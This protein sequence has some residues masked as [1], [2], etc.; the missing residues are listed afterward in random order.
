MSSAI[1]YFDSPQPFSLESGD[2]LPTLRI[3]YQTFGKLNAQQD[4]VIWVCHALTGNTEIDDWWSGL[5]GANNV[6]DPDQY[7]IV[8]ANMLGSCYGSTDALHI[9]PAT[10]TSW[11][12]NFPPI[13]NRDM[14][15]AFDMLRQHLGIRSIYLIT[16]GSMGGQHALEW[17]ISSPTLFRY[18]VPMATNAWHSP[19]G[20]AFNESQRMAIEADPSWQTATADAGLIGLRAARATAMISYRSYETYQQTQTEEDIN[21]TDQ[22]KASS[23]QQYQ[24][25]KLSKRFHTFA[26]WTLSKAMDSHH[27]GRNR[28]GAVPAL[29]HIQANTL[30]I[31][32][33]SDS[34]FPIHEQVYL[35][36]HIPQAK[37]NI[38][39]SLYGHDGFLIEFEPIKRA[40][41]SFLKDS[42]V[43]A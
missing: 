3:A 23:Y 2:T 36:E 12:H 18:L 9:N 41:Q 34:L 31:G 4:N 8:C 24:G 33:S 17:A 27:V 20:I 6:F 22:Y 13:T 39:D 7:F 25:L 37:L 30:V 38:I 43:T 19:W 29:A 42:P 14:V 5:F 32:I 16:G 35:A 26:Y 15:S 40:V 11:Y 21:K 28:G 10:G 1:Q